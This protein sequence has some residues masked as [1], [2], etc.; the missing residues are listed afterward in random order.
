MTT[1]KQAVGS[2]GGSRNKP[3]YVDLANVKAALESFRG[4]SPFDHCVVDNFFEPS[5][6]K[7]IDEEF[8][9]YHC[10]SWFRYDNLIENKKA[11]N[12]WNAF[13]PLTYKVFEY[14]ISADFVNVLM[15]HV[16]VVLYGDP[17]LH[18]GGWHIHG[19]GG[20]LN[21]H[22]DYSIHPKLGLQRKLNLIVYVSKDFQPALHGGHLGLWRQHPDRVR[23]G[24]LEREIEPAFNRAVLFDTTQGSWHGISRP[25]VQPPGIYR[26]SLAAYYLC[27]PPPNVDRRGRALFAPRPEQ[28]GD[29]RV[30]RIIRLRGDERTSLGVYRTGE[31]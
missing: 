25:L 26:K 12:D 2:D 17:G 8:L 31:E 28:E 1:G 7:R 18:G 24:V 13:P 6:A 20:N 11:L 23:P 27:E 29:E 4:S 10:E 3:A 19:T 9:S 16:G 14:L 30:E 22:L 15:Q 21:P 5:V